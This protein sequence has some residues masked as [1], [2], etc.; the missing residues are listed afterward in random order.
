MPPSV[1]YGR[2]P[3]ISRDKIHPPTCGIVRAMQRDG[4]P[5]WHYYW[6]RGFAAAL[7][8]ALVLGL[9]WSFRPSGFDDTPSVAGDEQAT[10]NPGN[11][12]GGGGGGGGDDDEEPQADESEPAEDEGLSEEEAEELIAAARDPEETT[13][14]VLD[15]GGG[16]D[17]T[18]DVAEVLSELGYDVVAINAS[19]V[20][21]L[22]TTVL[23]TDGNEAEAEALRARDERFAEIAP[24]ERLSDGVDV[25]IVVGPDWG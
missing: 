24:N 10:E 14:Q 1:L 21:F 11:K 22:T 4:E 18:A 19:R 16:S 8:L 25:H 9:Y 6:R 20:D 5:E 3:P 15:A 7:V 13:V 17:A 12:G 2:A 23:F